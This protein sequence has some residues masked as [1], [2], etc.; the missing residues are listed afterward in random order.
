MKKNILGAFLT[1]VVLGVIL[2]CFHK[3][4]EDFKNPATTPEKRKQIIDE[5]TT[6]I[7]LMG[8]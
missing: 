1:G 8:G 6:S 4:Y 2:Y 5:T 7:L 3:T